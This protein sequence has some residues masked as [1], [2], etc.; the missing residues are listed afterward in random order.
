[1]ITFTLRSASFG[2]S[3]ANVVDDSSV[4]D[5]VGTVRTS[6]TEPK[7]KYYLE[8]SGTR[9]PRVEAT[10]VDVETAL[11]RDWLR[12]EQFGFIEPAV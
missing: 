2:S 5:V 10:L 4:V 12:C 9:R 7:I 6:G 1:M 8:A 3:A 11:K